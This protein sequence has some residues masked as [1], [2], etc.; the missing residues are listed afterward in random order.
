MNTSTKTDP[1]RVMLPA[2][3]FT[4]PRCSQP[5]VTS[6]GLLAHHCRAKPD[7]ARLTREEVA[8]ALAGPGGA[9]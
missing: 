5:G 6:R 7:R 1:A 4:C 8:T 2:A 3:L 9:K